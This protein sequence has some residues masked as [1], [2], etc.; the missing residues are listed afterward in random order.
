MTVER[1]ADAV[2]GVRRPDALQQTRRLLRAWEAQGRVVCF[3]KGLYDLVR[4]EVRLDPAPYGRSVLPKTSIQLLRALYPEV[5]HWPS[6]ALAAAWRAYS[7]LYGSPLLPILE[8]RE[9]A[10]LEYLMVRELHPTE[11]GLQL[12]AR[13]EA[14]CQETLFYRLGTVPV[15]TEASPQPPEVTV[16]NIEAGLIDFKVLARAT[17]LKLQRAHERPSETN[18]PS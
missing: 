16:A 2:Y 6:T 5:G 11:T 9:A 14:L 18:S 4:P 13:Y 3:A 7:R 12:D 17:R 15:V 8:Q 10:F 1:L